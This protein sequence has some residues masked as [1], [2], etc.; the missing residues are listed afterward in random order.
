M[1]FVSDI[2]IIDL[3]KEIEEKHGEDT[4]MVIEVVVK[5]EEHI[6]VDEDMIG[7]LKESDVMWWVEFENE[8]KVFDN[9][10]MVKHY[11]LNE[12]LK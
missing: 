9:F 10:S 2:P 12:V 6:D 5:N 1:A 11:F 3:I 8:Q 7:N 4:H